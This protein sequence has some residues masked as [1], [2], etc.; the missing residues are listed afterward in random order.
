ML[1]F[2]RREF[3][4]W[5]ICNDG[6]VGI[7]GNSESDK[8]NIQIIIFVIMQINEIKRGGIGQTAI[9]CWI[10]RFHS[11]ESVGLFSCQSNGFPNIQITVGLKMK[12][13]NHSGGI[14][15]A[16]E[17]LPAF[18]FDVGN[19]VVG[20]IISVRNQDCF[21]DRRTVSMAEPRMRISS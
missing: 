18:L 10:V 15:D 9:P 8:T 20:F 21:R 14:P 17:I 3:I 5:Q 2:S 16:D 12:R 11:L 13:P 6:L 4:R 7:V 1:S 19:S